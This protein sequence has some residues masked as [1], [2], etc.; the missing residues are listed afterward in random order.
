MTELTDYQA[1]IANYRRLKAT[2]PFGPALTALD[3]A[4]ECCPLDE[5]LPTLEQY[6]ADLVPLTSPA[7]LWKRVLGWQE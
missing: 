6:R 3:A 4:I 1:N 7:P 2:G 5:C